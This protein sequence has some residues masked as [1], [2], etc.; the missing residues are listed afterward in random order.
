MRRPPVIQDDCA[1][2]HPARQGPWTP[3]AVEQE[4]VSPTQIWVVNTP[5]K[6]SERGSCSIIKNTGCI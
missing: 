2:L 5:L 6:E 1:A 4:A 3:W